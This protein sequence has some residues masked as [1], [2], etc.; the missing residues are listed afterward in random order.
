MLF[1]KVNNAAKKE[2][3]QAVKQADQ[4]KWYR[5]LKVIALSGQGQTVPELA[6]L[7][8]L[9]QATVRSYIKRYNADRLSG[10]RPNYGPGRPAKISLDKEQLEELLSRSPSQFEKL[11]TGARNWNQGLMQQYLSQYHQIELSQ[12]AISGTFRRLGISWNRAKKSDLP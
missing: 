8:D 1:A 12:G 4:T 7:F 11:N 6:K 10:L 5:R 2:L 3:E 9:N